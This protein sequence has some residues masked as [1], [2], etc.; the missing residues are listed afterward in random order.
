MINYFKYLLI[1]IFSSFSFANTIHVATTGSDNNDGSEG[2]PFATIQHGI[3]AASDGDTVLVAVGTYVESINYNSKQL[4]VASHFISSDG[5]DDFISNTI[6]DG[7]S[8]ASCVTMNGNESEL[9]G[10]TLTNGFST[11]EGNGSAV[12]I[13]AASELSYCLLINNY[14][15][16][17]II[18]RGY[19]SSFDH[20]TIYDN[21]YD[22]AI[23]GYDCCSESDEFNFSN[24]IFGYFE[25][26]GGY[27]PTLNYSNNYS[28]NEVQWD[29]YSPFFCN[30]DSGDYS[31]AENSP[32]AGAGE[33]GSN[34]GA[35]GVGCGIINQILNV[36]GDYSTIQAG[37]DAAS[38]GDTVF[39]AAG[40]YVE[41]INYN[42]KNIA[43]IGE[44]RETTIIDGNQNG[45]VVVFENGVDS[46]AVLSGF[47]IQNGQANYG[48]IK[49]RSGTSPTLKDLIVKNNYSN[50]RGGGIFI[51]SASPNLS[52][53]IIKDNYGHN[54]GGGIDI[55]GNSNP[56]L[57][58]MLI[59]NNSTNN[60]GGGISISS[61]SMVL[62]G[63]T[64]ANNSANSQ[65]SGIYSV[66][67]TATSTLTNCIIWNNLPSEINVSGDSLSI[68]YSNIEGGWEGGGNIDSDPL[69]CNPDSG[70][71]SL[72]ENSPAVGAGENGIDMGTLG[73]GCGRISQIIHVSTTG[74]DETGNGSE[75][76][77]FATIEKAEGFANTFYDSSHYDHWNSNLGA[78]VTDTIMVHDGT[79][80]AED[81]HNS[82]SG[83]LFEFGANLINIIVSKNGPEHTF[84]QAVDVGG[85][86]GS[87]ELSGFTLIGGDYGVSAC[88][89]KFQNCIVKDTERFDATTCG[90]NCFL[91]YSTTFI[92]NNNTND[93]YNFNGPPLFINS[94]ILNNEN[95]TIGSH[96]DAGSMSFTFNDLGF[97]ENGNISFDEN[98]DISDVNPFFCDPDSGDYSLA[99]NSPAIGAGE[100]GIDMGALGVGCE[101]ISLAPTILEKVVPN[102]FAI[103]QNYPNPFNPTTTLKYDLPEDAMVN[104]IIY[105]MMG[106]AVKTMVNNQQNAGFKSVHWNATNDNGFPV[107]AGLYLYSIQAGEF[108]Q[109]KKMVL[110][111]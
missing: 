32:A 78:Y 36:P 73:V 97:N 33:G 21:G 23:I 44:N 9:I 17:A 98:G 84:L 94:I 16:A 47:T 71:Y 10:F 52:F 108:R 85:T 2:N 4:V 39:V 3:N 110:L 26:Y 28:Y 81:L 88:Y 7:D 74:S 42:G 34:I 13:S 96:F 48:G 111:K 1:I 56:S 8:T 99:S 60:S 63:S 107:S 30:P 102:V 35:L 77:P 27:P 12:T 67:N 57:S 58:N 61:G 101:A 69:F 41:N 62:T 82:F 86:L 75:E 49:I 93:N 54:G 95:L 5:D 40:T 59:I 64:I 65:G 70:D 106:R 24:S 90:M 19:S 46:T 104:I 43:V 89:I 51:T 14:G 68:S 103:H 100:N 37:I 31:L 79:Y 105:D 6:I 25:Q 22:N 11:S 109:T 38:D 76:N 66:N 18:I 50:D 72:A 55:Y 29:A 92:D 87:Y 20:L 83:Y 15:N 45:S 91:F 53:I 80:T